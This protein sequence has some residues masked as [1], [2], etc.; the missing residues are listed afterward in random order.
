MH[1]VDFA[2]CI[3]IGSRKASLF[4]KVLLIN[5]HFLYAKITSQYWSMTAPRLWPIAQSKIT[6]PS[7]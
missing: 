6:Y 3:V 4:Q 2:R 1:P 5:H 7:V